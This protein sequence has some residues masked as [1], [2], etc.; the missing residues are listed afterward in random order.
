MRE[1]SI[2]TAPQYRP[3]PRPRPKP[4]ANTT[5]ANT[6]S[7]KLYSLAWLPMA[8]ENGFPRF[9]RPC[10]AASAMNGSWIRQWNKLDYER[11]CG[12]G[13]NQR[14]AA[15]QSKEMRPDDAIG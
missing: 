13:S 6:K 5:H 10:T 15:L 14:D 11:I 7:R 3:G 8:L 1:V 2:T 12:M 9:L 4:K